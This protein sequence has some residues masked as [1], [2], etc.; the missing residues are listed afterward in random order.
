MERII[1]GNYKPNL[2]HDE[3]AAA[4]VQA[5]LSFFQVVGGV[6]ITLDYPDQDDSIVQAVIAVHNPLAESVNEKQAR[7][8]IESM[9]YLKNVD[10]EGLRA[11]IL[12][13]PVAQRDILAPLAKSVRAL[14]I[15][16]TQMDKEIN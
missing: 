4:G 3:L 15:I 16:V 11:A 5:T 7:R 8:Y 1:V 14:S 12:S 13:L 10:W 2:L 9:N 6:E